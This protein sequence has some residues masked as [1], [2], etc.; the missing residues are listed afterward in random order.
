MDLYTHYIFENISIEVI[1][2]LVVS[3]VRISVVRMLQCLFLT[4]FKFQIINILFLV[5]ERMS[6]K[7]QTLATFGYTKTILH[8]GGDFEPGHV[9]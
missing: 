8:R 5:V 1:A 6:K 3:L 2:V 9:S 7:Q 4:F